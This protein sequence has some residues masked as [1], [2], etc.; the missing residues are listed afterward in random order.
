MKT[1]I[2]AAPAEGI[3]PHL[4]G[5][6]KQSS[7]KLLLADMWV[8]MITITHTVNWSKIAAFIVVKYAYCSLIQPTTLL[9]NVCYYRRKY[10]IVNNYHYSRRPV[11]GI[12]YSY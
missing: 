11:T 6:A 1:R 12:S 5:V 10:F 7:E 9:Y 2:Y 3:L 8:C 4:Y